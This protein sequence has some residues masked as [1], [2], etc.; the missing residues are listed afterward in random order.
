MHDERFALV[1]FYSNTPSLR[2]EKIIVF[3]VKLSFIQFNILW[4]YHPKN[5]LIVKQKKGTSQKMVKNRNYNQ[6]ILHLIALFSHLAIG[7]IASQKKLMLFTMKFA[8]F[9][10]IPLF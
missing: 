10:L 3:P 1:Y 2:A 7:D 5:T 4:P 8:R 6:Q 9:S